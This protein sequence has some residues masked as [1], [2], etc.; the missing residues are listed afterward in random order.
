MWQVRLI[1]NPHRAC[2]T[3]R[4]SSILPTSGN[5]CLLCR[6]R[7]HRGSEACH[8]HGPVVFLP[9]V[10]FHREVIGLFGM[11]VLLRGLVSKHL[12]DALISALVELHGLG[13]GDSIA[14]GLNI[15][16]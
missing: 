15:Q 2:M 12:T 8:G 10:E 6:P 1:V 4:W 7:P 5:K 9:I 3:M 11:V 14:I 16:I 13:Q